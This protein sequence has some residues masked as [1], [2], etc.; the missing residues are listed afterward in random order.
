MKY[1]GDELQFD[2]RTLPGWEEADTE[3]RKRI[4]EA[5]KRYVR[6]GEPQNDEWVGT[7]TLFR[8]AFSGYRAW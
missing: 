2:L 5:G 6:E 7:N 4:V 1:Y 8:P 3:T